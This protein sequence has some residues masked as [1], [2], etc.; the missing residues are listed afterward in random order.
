MKTDS[1]ISYFCEECEHINKINEGE[2]FYYG[3]NSNVRKRSNE[4]IR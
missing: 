1:S 3:N 4:N 2:I